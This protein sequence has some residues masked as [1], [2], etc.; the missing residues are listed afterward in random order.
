MSRPLLVVGAALVDAGGRVLVARRSAPKGLAGLWEFPGGKVDAGESP[1]D[2]LLRE[3]R[4]ELGVGVRLGDPLP[5][6]VPDDRTPA[7]TWPLASGVM[8]VWWATVTDGVPRPLQDHDEVR[9]VAPA[10][11]SEVAWVPADRPI[12]D[13]VAQE[14][15]HVARLVVVD[16]GDQVAGEGVGSPATGPQPAPLT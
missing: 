2:A 12:A 13:A 8:A 10:E 9:W 14:A 16:V 1:G 15:E 7:G 6:P 11:L 5:G 3:L 4:E